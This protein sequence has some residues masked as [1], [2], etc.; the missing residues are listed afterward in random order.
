M[1]DRQIKI[2]CAILCEEV[3]REYNGRAIIL[4]AAMTGPPIDQQANSLARLALY[5]EIF[6]KNCPVVEVRLWNKDRSLAIIEAEFNLETK[7]EF[8]AENPETRYEDV[9]IGAVMVVNQSDITVFGDSVYQLQ[10]KSKDESEWILGRE[11]YF[12]VAT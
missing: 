8:E 3:R 12:P 9:E 4:G 6:A 11:F 10:M 1:T 2:G 5:I 7:E